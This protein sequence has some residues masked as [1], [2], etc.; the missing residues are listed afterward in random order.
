MKLKHLENYC[1]QAFAVAELSP[2][3]EKK[4]GAI[5]INKLTGAVLANGYNGF[6][7][8]AADDK[9]P[10]TRPDKYE[11]IIHAEANLINNCARHGIRTEDCFVFCTLSPCLNCTRTLFQSGIDT[12]VFK[13]EYRGFKDQQDAKDLFY[14][15]HQIGEFT[16]LTV[17]PRLDG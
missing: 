17:R 1:K 14:E 9:L 4:V 15:R 11:F 8:G 10:K 5:L 2:D 16:V 6:I 12:V 3:A 13:D 7:R